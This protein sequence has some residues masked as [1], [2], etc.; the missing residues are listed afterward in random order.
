MAKTQLFKQFKK[1]QKRLLATHKDNISFC[2][3]LHKYYSLNNSFYFIIFI[4]LII[5]NLWFVTRIILSIWLSFVKTILFQLSLIYTL[6]NLI[7]YIEVKY[8]QLF[9]FIFIF[10]IIFL[11]LLTKLLSTKIKVL[12]VYIFIIFRK[13]NF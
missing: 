3:F 11:S 7:S 6:I 12:L 4:K 8:L 2:N 10:L 5:F 9:I 13:L 1:D